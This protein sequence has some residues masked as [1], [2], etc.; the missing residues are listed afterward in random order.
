[1]ASKTWFITGTSSGLGHAW[2]IAALERG[3]R[4]AG[5]A[6]DIA[7]LAELSAAYGDLFLPLELEVKD[8]PGVFAA[9]AQAHERFGRLDVVINNAGYGHL[10][11]VEE[12]SETVARDQ[13]DANFFGALWVTQAAL[14][15]LRAQAAGHIIQVSSV[16]GVTAVPMLS[17]YSA[18]KWALEGLSEALAGEVGRFGIKVT[19]VEPGGYRTA[20]G[21]KPGPE[22]TPIDAYAEGRQQMRRGGSALSGDPMATGAAILAVVDAE[23]PPLRL[24]LGAG[25]LP[26]I[27]EALAARLETWRVWEPTA[28]AAQGSPSS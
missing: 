7:R 28:L 15:L 16:A 1:M 14:P 4:V 5:T 12:V 20:Q 24:M 27:E 13:F 22:V 3:D 9:V 19:I 17:L 25:L 11:A 10:A 26:A 8:R 18:S 2:A 23:D 6:R 21:S